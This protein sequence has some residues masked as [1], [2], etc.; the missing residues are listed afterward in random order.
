MFKS[1]AGLWL[2][3]FG[4]LFFLLYPSDF[5]PIMRFNEDIEGKRFSEIYK[6]TFSLIEKQLVEVPVTRWQSDIQQLSLHFRYDLRL[7]KSSE[8]LLKQRQKKALQQGQIVFINAEPE[9]LLKQIGKSDFTLQLFTDFSEDM[10]ISSGAT[11]TVFLLRQTFNQTTS[12]QWPLLIRQLEEMFPYYLRVT[13]SGNI[14]PD[15]QEKHSL[16]TYFFFWRGD[17]SKAVSF[18]IPLKSGEFFLIADQVPMSPVDT[19]AI[20]LLI[21]L[22][23]FTISVFMFFWVYPLW[24]DLKYL[25]SATSEFGKGNLSTRAVVTKISVVAALSRAF[26]QMA[27]RTEHLLHGQR[28]LTN[29]IAHDL[30]TPLYRLRFAF[31]M[32]MESKRSQVDTKYWSSI[33][34][35][36]DD[37]DH[38]INQTLLLS[39]YSSDR[40]L[41]QLAEHDLVTLINE[42][43]LQ[44][45]QLWPDI[46]YQLDLH[47]EPEQA[48]TPVDG[49]AIKRAISNLLTNAC[50]F[51]RSSVVV[52]LHYRQ[53][54]AE[55]VLEVS[56]D[57]PGIPEDHTERIFLPFE[58][59]SSD[60]RDIAS[61]HGLGLAIVR[62]IA[63]WH[64]G[65]VIAGRSDLGGAS[66][67]FRWPSQ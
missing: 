47:L 42:E 62:Y 27:E 21:L 4:P 3:V 61:G 54:S 60:R 51:A 26:N 1:F 7:L 64:S 6:G 13:K 35:S 9:Y 22:I 16:K 20:I 59:L 67:V 14:Q 31:E 52:K 63:R 17:P 46:D 36:I 8:V 5:N 45:F 29:A 12:A 58:Q 41:I 19:S 57:G 55:Y 43:C 10:K 24:R 25:V 38:L 28:T 11:G 39:R 53:P 44:I 48:I 66:F 32:L 65:T 33:S 34:K 18:Y 15:K 50:K 23:V 37:L 2:L 49:I 30:R 56:D 40:E